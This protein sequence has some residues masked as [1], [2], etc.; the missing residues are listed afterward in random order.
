MLFN[1]NVPRTKLLNFQ[2]FLSACFTLL[3]VAVSPAVL[4]RLVAVLAVLHLCLFGYFP[5]TNLA[6]RAD[7]CSTSLYF[8]FFLFSM[9]VQSGISKPVIYSFCFFLC[10][11]LLSIFSILF[12]SNLLFIPCSVFFLFIHFIFWF[13]LLPSFQICYPFF[14]LFLL[15]YS[16]YF[17][18]ILCYFS[19]CF[20]SINLHFF[21]SL[22]LI[23]LYYIFCSCF[24]FLYSSSFWWRSMTLPVL[25]SFLSFCLFSFP[26]F[27][28][29]S[30]YASILLLFL[31]FHFFCSLLSSILY[32]SPPLTIDLLIFLVYF[33]L[34][35]HS[36]LLLLFS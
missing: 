16:V 28:F 1:E 14:S 3:T 19:I 22:Y 10:S 25:C 30:F 13:P 20:L 36:L 9:F 7:N 11:F 2:F 26:L 5:S 6:D 23:L 34:F 15:L 17:S 29:C 33:Y 31:F 4:A 24:C 12:F 18:L 27:S 32:A 8:L 35:I 21:R